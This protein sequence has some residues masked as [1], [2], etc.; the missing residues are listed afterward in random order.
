MAKT[1]IDIFK[2]KYYTPMIQISKQYKNI[3]IDILV[4]ISLNTE[5]EKETIAAIDYVGVDSI[6]QEGDSNVSF[7]KGC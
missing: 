4:V 1:S 7:R 6:K 3:C 5:L 2:S